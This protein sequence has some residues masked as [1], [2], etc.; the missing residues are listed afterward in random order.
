MI[1]LFK[2]LCVLVMV[3]VASCGG[4]DIDEGEAP[5]SSP[6]AA[7]S[8]SS[9]VPPPPVS[10]PEAWYC[11]LLGPTA[12]VREYG[13]SGCCGTFE[14]ALTPKSGRLMKNTG[15][16]SE[17]K[18]WVFYFA[19]DGARYRFPSSVVLD[20]W[21][22]SRDVRGAPIANPDICNTVIEVPDAV[23]ASIRIGG[24]V[25]MRPGTYTVGIWSDP[26]IY[27]VSK[28]HVLRWIYDD[29]TKVALFGGEY[30]FRTRIIPDGDFVDYMI[31]AP[32]KSAE[33]YSIADALAVTIEQDLGIAP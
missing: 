16:S 14:K 33:D 11:N 13:Y 26:K 31:G 17:P 3:F 23:L 2:P 28:G 29:P 1:R 21:Y 7:P 9:T 20:S 4:R 15:S 18:E 10:K 8:G 27:A 12:T 22:G 19:T 32:I 24:V 5:C 6:S 30:L 25:T